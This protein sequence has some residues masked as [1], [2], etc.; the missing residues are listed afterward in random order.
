[1]FT[2]TNMEYAYKAYKAKDKEI[3]DFV[4]SATKEAQKHFT[5][6][7]RKQKS[8]EYNEKLGKLIEEQDKIAEELKS[9]IKYLANQL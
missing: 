4:K 1:M 6:E 3:W 9:Y 8:K 2:Y 7:E 5:P